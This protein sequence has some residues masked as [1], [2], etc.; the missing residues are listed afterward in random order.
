MAKALTAKLIENIKPGTARRE[1]PDARTPGLYLIVQPSGAKSWAV[2]YRHDGK[3]RKLTLDRYPRLGL[4]AARDAANSALTKAASGLDP[5]AAKQEA[6][7]RAP[8][9]HASDRVP[10]IVELFI[11]R[12][13]R[14]NG[15]RSAEE[16]ARVLRREV[17]GPWAK[18]DI[19]Q[20]TRREIIALLDGIVD[21][22][23]P[24]TANR[25]HRHI[26]K[27]MNWCVDRG[28]IETSPC[29]RLKAPAA[30]ISRDRVLTDDEIRWFWQTAEGYGYPYGPL[31]Q[32]LLLTGQRRN[33]VAG[34]SMVRARP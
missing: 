17:V 30:E 11:A 28:I 3:S 25:V 4:A 8:D 27:L 14:Q 34:L 32:L 6:K 7:R 29:A 15:H 19:K 1:V 31:Y 22:G 2:R 13:V 20:I 24:H 5:A 10:A 33:E 18:L 23:A 12:H 21:R 9:E 16:T 26:R